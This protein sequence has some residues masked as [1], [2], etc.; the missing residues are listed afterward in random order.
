MSGVAGDI[1]IGARLTLPS[2]NTIEV[3]RSDGDDWVCLYV[4]GRAEAMGEVV[5]S[6]SRLR[7]WLDG[8][9]SR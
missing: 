5:F 6:A 9:T 7:R 8:E 4:R 2:G 3:L 1:P